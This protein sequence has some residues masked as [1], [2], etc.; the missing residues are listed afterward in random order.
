MVQTPNIT[1]LGCNPANIWPGK[2]GKITSLVMHTMSGSYEGTADWFR[3]PEAQ[4]SSNYGVAED[5]RAACFVDPF[6]ADAPFAN[7]AVVNPDAEFTNWWNA[8]GR[9]NPN[10]ITCSI[11]HEDKLVP[12]HQ[13]TSS[14]SQ[15]EGST[16]ISAWVCSR[17]GIDPNAPGSFLGHYQIDSVNR[18]ACPGWTSATWDSYILEVTHK[19]TG[20]SP[21]QPVILTAQQRIDRLDA[22]VAGNGWSPDFTKDSAGQLHPVGLRTGE[23]AI[24]EL[25]AS[26]SSVFQ[27]LMECS[28]IIQHPG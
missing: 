10:Y 23:A 3:H 28:W 15:F 22:L 26:G 4:A 9:V 16:L 27:G 1:F 5:G 19:M 13:I 25:A 8:N 17:L 11:E 2:R 20:Q 7:G 6:G 21:I 24:A 14:P 18:A 12:N